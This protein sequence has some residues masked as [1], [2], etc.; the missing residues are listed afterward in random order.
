MLHNLFSH[1]DTE[2]SLQT[3]RAW[4][5]IFIVFT[6]SL[7]TIRLV[8][9]TRRDGR[10]AYESYYHDMSRFRD[11]ECLKTRTLH[12]KGVLPDDR[13]GNG[14]ELHL[15]KILAQKTYTGQL[16]QQGK[17]RS[18]LIIPDFTKQ[19]EIEIKI[20]DL[21]DYRVLMTVLKP[22]CMQ[23]MLVPSSYKK[24]KAFEK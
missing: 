4:I 6:F 1:S 14:I 20:Q 18:V 24:K 12:V 16:N 22:N 8:Q 9:K 3:H 17:V 23:N 19:F 5:S 10:I 21:K 11:H 15:N 13:T 2:E 7:L